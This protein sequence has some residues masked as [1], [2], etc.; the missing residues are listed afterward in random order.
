MIIN[1]YV[2]HSSTDIFYS[3]QFIYSTIIARLD[4]VLPLN[5][6]QLNKLVT[7]LASST[8]Y[9][10]K[11][12]KLVSFLTYCV[13]EVFQPSPLLVSRLLAIVSLMNVVPN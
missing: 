4:V 9:V 12:F 3:S 13:L 11:E 6:I 5:V 2:C 7:L 1:F 8:K 10:E